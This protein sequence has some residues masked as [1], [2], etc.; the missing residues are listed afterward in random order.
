MNHLPTADGPSAAASSSFNRRFVAFT[1]AVLLW[2][3]LVSLWGA[4]VRAS[5]SGNGCGDHW[6]LCDGKLVPMNPKVATMIELFHRLTSGV[7]L[8]AVALLLVWAWRVYPRRHRV[9]TGALLSTILLLNEALIGAALVLFQQVGT[10]ASLTRAGFLS[11]HLINTFLL[12]GVLTLTAW[13]ASGAPAPARN[14]SRRL[15]WTTLAVLAGTIFLG[16]SGAIAALGDTLFPAQS[17]AGSMRLDFSHAAPVLLRARVF[18]PL[19]ATV[20]GL[21]LIAWAQSILHEGVSRR[22]RRLGVV[23]TALVL[24]QAG[25]G[26]INISLLAPVWM[27]IIHLAGAYLLWVTLVLLANELLAGD[28]TSAGRTARLDGQVVAS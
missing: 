12:L 20:I 2:N 24:V 6:P 28:A 10:N 5:G 17:L 25:L 19:V 9:R 16:V 21:V 3:I 18:H 8:V 27:Q 14:G 4:Y 1:W 22:A 13:W 23:L 11:V 15:L 26:V 7:D